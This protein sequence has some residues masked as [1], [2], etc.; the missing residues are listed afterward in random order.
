[1]ATDEKQITPTNNGVPT[2]VANPSRASWRTFVQSLVSFLL[3]LN[4]AAGVLA[5]FLTSPDAADLR[6]LISPDIY[7]WIVLILNGIV[8]VGSA[9]SKLVAL[10]MA[11]PT[12]NAWITKHLSWLA[13]IRPS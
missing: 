8:V 5:A 6:E 4:I 9:V 7:G 1:M 13:P 3:V 11:N 10:L 2:Q 12:I